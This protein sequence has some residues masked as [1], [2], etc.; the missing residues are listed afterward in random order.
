LSSVVETV[1]SKSHGPVFAADEFR[2]G[3]IID[4]SPQHPAQ[5]ETSEAKNA[6]PLPAPVHPAGVPVSAGLE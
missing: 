2:P 1:G 3:L 4:N 6:Y 5:C